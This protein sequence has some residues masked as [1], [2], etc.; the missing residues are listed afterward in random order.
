MATGIYSNCM[1]GKKIGPKRANKALDKLYQAEN[2][3]IMQRIL[4]AT[5][6]IP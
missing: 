6:K 3:K 1:Q 4:D 2:N 5:I